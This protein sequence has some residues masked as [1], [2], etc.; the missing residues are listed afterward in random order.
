MLQEQIKKFKG[1]TVL[2]LFISLAMVSEVPNAS[3]EKQPV[4]ESKIVCRSV[5]SVGSRIPERV[6]RTK[7]E[8]ANIAEAN[9]EQLKNR[10]S[11]SRGTQNRN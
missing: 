6:C 7:K 4:E 11:Y 8:W 1:N 10:S 5:W 9:Q 3:E 2:S